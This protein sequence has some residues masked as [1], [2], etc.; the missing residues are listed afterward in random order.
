MNITTDYDPAEAYADFAREAAEADA[1]EWEGPD[2]GHDDEDR[3]PPLVTETVPVAC[4]NCD[5]DAE[6]TVLASATEER[7]VLIVGA[8]E[9]WHVWITDAGLLAANCGHRECA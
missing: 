8:P 4:N 5:A 6:A 7:V 3:D 1:F 9:G 2:D